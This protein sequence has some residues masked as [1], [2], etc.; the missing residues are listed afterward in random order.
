VV[1]QFAAAALV[2]GSGATVRGLVMAVNVEW[3][4]AHN[5][6]MWGCLKKGEG[7]K[8]LVLYQ[9]YLL[10]YQRGKGLVL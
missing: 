10:V 4:T 1:R 7:G 5:P 8:G 9:Q 3:G 6:P 2:L